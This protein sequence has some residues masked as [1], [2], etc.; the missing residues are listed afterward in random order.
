[1]QQ[2]QEL[3]IYDKVNGRF[4]LLDLT[5]HVRAELTTGEIT[6][7]TQGLKQRAA[8]SQDPL[9]KF[10]ATPTFEEQFDEASGELTLTSP[11]LIYRVHG[12]NIEDHEVVAQ[13]RE[14]SDWLVQLNP[15]LSPGG[16]PPFARLAVNKALD[17]HNLIVRDVSL[18]TAPRKGPP[19]KT[20][21]HSQRT[22]GA[23]AGFARRPGADQTGPAVADGLQTDRY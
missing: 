6:T 10:M 23:N 3:I 11:W 2:P 7:F 13:Y 12:Q 15:I 4:D 17:T 16:R 9:I 5:R 8:G 18:T 20:K 21:H 22:P 1:M 19:A 14:F